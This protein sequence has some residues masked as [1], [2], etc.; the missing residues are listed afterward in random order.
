[1]AALAMQLYKLCFNPRTY[2]YTQYSSLQKSRN[3]ALHAIQETPFVQQTNGHICPVMP[4][5]RAALFIKT[6]FIKIAVRKT[7]TPKY[8]IADYNSSHASQEMFI[9]NL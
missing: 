3:A 8:W 6:T 5:I 9:I 4:T 1:M 2:Q 7:S